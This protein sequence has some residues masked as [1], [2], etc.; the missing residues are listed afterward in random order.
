MIEPSARRA[1]TGGV[2]QLTPV[3]NL[4]LAC[5][6]GLA[7]MSSLGLPWYGA[8]VPTPD[9]LG[10]MEATGER[11]ARVFTNDA[12]T[13]TGS[14][15]LADQRVLVF[16]AVLAVIGLCS[17]MLIPVIRR[18]LCDALRALA[19]LLPI[20]VLVT[21]INAADGMELRWGLIVSVA[22]GLF[23]ANASWHGASVRAP[24]KPAPPARA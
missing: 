7:L 6:A 4:I 17:V 8:P 15:A 23:M 5:F 18:A 16:G 1:D 24:R 3:T 21:A 13:T 12:A 14:D 10:P 19:L 20:A 22:I 2:R 11:L 9:G